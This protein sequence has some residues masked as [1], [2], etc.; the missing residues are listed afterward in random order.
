MKLNEAE[1]KLTTL[2]TEF[3]PFVPAGHLFFGGIHRF[4]AFRAFCNVHR[5]KRHCLTIDN[6]F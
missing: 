5:F 4:P 6:G 3:M 2:E 1:L